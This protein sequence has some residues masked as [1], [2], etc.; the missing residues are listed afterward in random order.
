MT[1]TQLQALIDIANQNGIDAA[2]EQFA[3]SEQDRYEADCEA[4]DM[5][6]D[7]CR[8]G[9]YVPGCGE[10]DTVDARGRPL[11]SRFNE[12]GEPRW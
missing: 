11:L 10:Y 12:A 4:M 1:K 6:R 5:E 9:R 7:E 2:Y 8:D 3:A